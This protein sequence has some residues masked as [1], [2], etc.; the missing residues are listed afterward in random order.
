MTAKEAEGTEM[1]SK[2]II[3]MTIGLAIYRPI[4]ASADA[5]FDAC[6]KKLCVSTSQM[7][8]WVKAGAALCDRDQTQCKDIP[9]HAGAVVI[10]KVQRRWE[11]VTVYGRGWVSDRMMMISG[12]KC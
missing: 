2:V 11:V 12:D 3:Y 6:I 4:P 9:D 1:S 5:S 8:C 10:R 7:N